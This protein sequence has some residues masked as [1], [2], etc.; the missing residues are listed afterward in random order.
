M[1]PA[2]ICLLA[3]ACASSPDATAQSSALTSGSIKTVFLI[4]MENHSWSEIK[5]SSSASYING[6]LAPMASHAEAYRNPGYL[7]PSLPNYLWL[8]AGT[9][10]G[11]EADGDPSQFHQ[12]STQHFVTLLQGAGHSWK[13]YLEGIDGTSCP[14][15]GSGKFAPRHT[16]PLYFDDVTASSANCLAHVRPYGELATDLANGTQPEFVYIT[17]DLCDDMHDT[18]GCPSLDSIRNGDGWLATEVPKILASAAYRNGGALFI[19]WDE[20]EASE[21]PM[22]MFVLSPL[23]KGNGYASAVNFTHSSTLRTFEEIFGL[24]PFLGGAADA[25]DLSDLFTVELAQPCKTSGQCGSGQACSATGYCQANPP[26]GSCQADSDCTGGQACVVG[27]CDTR[28]SSSCPPGTTDIGGT[29]V[30][31]GCETAGGGWPLALAALAL[32]VAA[33]RLRNHTRS[34]A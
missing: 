4:I 15:T 28:P 3:V 24:Q 1:R 33:R 34:R 26:A 10:F 5:G 8:E 14:L 23:A 25:A 13:A 29:C 30:P 21:E 7:H 22:P 32:L 6:T 20:S 11:I 31:T 2:L 19:T 18:I 27:T 17:P 9:N 16:G 12:G